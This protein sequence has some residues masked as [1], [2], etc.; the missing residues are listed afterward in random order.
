MSDTNYSRKDFINISNTWIDLLTDKKD[1]VSTSNP[2]AF[3]LG[4]QAGAGK[5]TLHRYI[6]EELNGNVIVIDNDSFKQSHPNLDQLIQKYGKNYIE[7][8]TPFS[9]ELTEY[10]IN[11]L[12]DLN[13][14]LIIEGTLR[15]TETPIK[16]AE[17]LKQKKYEVNLYV[18]AVSKELS[19]LAIDKRYEEGYSKNPNTAR[20]TPKDIHDTIVNNLPDNIETLYE[21]QIFKDI[22]L[23]NRQGEELYQMNE[24]PLKSPRNALKNELDRKLAKEEYL[25]EVNHILALAKINDRLGDPSIKNLLKK[26]EKLT[27]I[28]KSDLFCI[29]SI[30]KIDRHINQNNQNKDKNKDKKLEK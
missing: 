23:I 12:S 11:R 7:K 27:E 29:D 26:K 2:K 28:E 22:K 3:L 9:N 18:M 25:N 4:G 6:S 5:T 19:S 14:N 1:V 20:H 15:T 21:K 13:Y 16:T 10:L 8:V 17:L 24:N 30:K